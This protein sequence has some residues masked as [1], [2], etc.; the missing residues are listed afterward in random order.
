M[1]WK[2]Y[3]QLRSQK[4]KPTRMAPAMDALDYS[5]GQ[6]ISRV[7]PSMRFNWLNLLLYLIAID[8]EIKLGKLGEGGNDKNV[9]YLMARVLVVCKK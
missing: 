5:R 7:C 4:G 2:I 1:Y 6:S 9:H 8:L 3:F